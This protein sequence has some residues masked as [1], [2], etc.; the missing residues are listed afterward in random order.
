MPKK[1]E[2]KWEIIDEF[3][4]GANFTSTARVKVIGG[5]IVLHSFQRKGQISESMIFVNDRE[6]EWYIVKP[7]KEPDP[8][9][10]KPVSEGY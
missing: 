6:Y 7:I 10:E 5:W 9:V 3:G 2:W 4:D 1:I 8:Q